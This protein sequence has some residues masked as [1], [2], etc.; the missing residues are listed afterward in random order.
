MYEDEIIKE[1]R[2]VREEHASKFDFDIDKIFLD[3]KELEKKYAN[4]IV[5]LKPRRFG[6][7]KSENSTNL[8]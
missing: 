7:S 2:K 6:L 3:L 8:K 4:R 1:V 5:S